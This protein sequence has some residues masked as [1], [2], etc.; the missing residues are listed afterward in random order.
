M[1]MWVYYV[2]NYKGYCVEYLV[3]ELN[4]I[5]LVLYE[6]KRIKSVVILINLVLE[7]YKLF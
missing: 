5:F 4:M 2:N 7:I 6:G 1:F 3:E